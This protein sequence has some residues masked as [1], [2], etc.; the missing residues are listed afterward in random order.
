MFASKNHDVISQAKDVAINKE[1]VFENIDVQF[2]IIV[3]HIKLNCG[4]KVNTNIDIVEDIPIGNVEYVNDGGCKYFI[5]SGYRDSSWLR[6][7][8]REHES[9]VV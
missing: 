9:D 8:I 1:I 4:N 7:S 5:A 3:P 2:G 6:Q